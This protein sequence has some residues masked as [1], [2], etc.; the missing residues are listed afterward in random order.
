M[1]GGPGKS[2]R[3]L[4]SAITCLYASGLRVVFSLFIFFPSSDLQ[5]KR[6]CIVL[7]LFIQST[8][9]FVLACFRT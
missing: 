9:F 4:C 2:N 7:L 3:A 6:S 8:S 1:D 5:G